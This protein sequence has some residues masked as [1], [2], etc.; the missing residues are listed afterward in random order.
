MN[1]PAL[2]RRIVEAL[3][4]VPVRCPDPVGP[5]SGVASA[6]GPLNGD[7]SSPPL[8]LA[9]LGDST[10]MGVGTPS[11]PE[12][13]AGEL[14]TALSEVSGRPVQWRAT[15]SAGATM[16]HV[17]TDLVPRL[18]EARE[19]HVIVVSAGVNDLIRLHR[20]STF[21][22]DLQVLLDSARA[23]L[24]RSVVVFGGMP[25]THLAPALPVPMARLVGHR[26]R[27][28]D[29]ETMAMT[30]QR[31]VA[32]LPLRALEFGP[33]CFAEDGFHPNEHGYRLWARHVAPTVYAALAVSAASGDWDP[34]L[35]T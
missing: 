29:L 13:L 14:A 32:F 6:E 2:Q 4:M 31:H 5:T 25:P 1:T 20:R 17:A 34:D 24:P 21:R 16:R 27:L 18:S 10:V 12:G 15:F 19:P 22:R 28:F 8:R 9:V 11:T 23:S 35:I 3:G 30:G 26:A 7:T 33:E